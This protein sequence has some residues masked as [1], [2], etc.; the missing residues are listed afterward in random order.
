MSSASVATLRRQRGN[1]LVVALIILGM[2]TLLAITNFRI[3]DSSLTV[4]GNM[5][6]QEA[7]MSAANGV[8]Q[9]AISTVRMIQNPTQI[10]TAPCGGVNNTRCVDLN[11]DGVNDVTVQLTP[12]PTCI[13][14]Q[15][16]PVNSLDVSDEEDRP[17]MQ[18]VA[19]TF[20]IAGAPSA[21]SLCANT[22]FEINAV[23]NDAV[24]AASVTL[25]EGVAVRATTDDVDTACPPV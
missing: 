1:S 20:G 3:S 25:T 5:Q 24:T 11:A 15:V 4:T 19:Q 8:I 14:A 6:Q 22:L 2:I 16:I 18:G 10:F 9:E 21:D 13:Q 17:C 12:A 7:V 23:A